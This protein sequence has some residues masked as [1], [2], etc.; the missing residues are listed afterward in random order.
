[1]KK[2]LVTGGCGYIG[3]HTIVD[4]VQ[5]GYEVICVDDLSRGSL[6][7]LHGIEKVLGRSIKNYKVNLCDLEDTEAIFT[8]NP[9][10]VGIIH[11]AAYKSVPE[12][13]MEPLMYFRNNI[14]SLVNL[15]Q[16]A[17]EYKVNHFV[18]SSSCSV[19]GNADQL[20]VEETAPLKEPLYQDSL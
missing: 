14:N 1:M 12:S 2:I 17:Q 18:F 11:F 4:L 16:C 13:V 7:M 9:D 19:Y 10:I 20:P 8:E 3:G 5:N 15:L 6:R